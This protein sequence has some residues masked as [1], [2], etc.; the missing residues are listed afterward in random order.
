MRKWLLISTLLTFRPRNELWRLIVDSIFGID[1]PELG[2]EC[3]E[4]ADLGLAGGTYQGSMYQIQVLVETEE[5]AQALHERLSS[6]SFADACLEELGL[7]AT[8]DTRRFQLV[9]LA[10]DS[11]TTCIV[12]RGTGMAIRVL[13]LDAHLMASELSVMEERNRELARRQ[14]LVTQIQ[15]RSPLFRFSRD[16]LQW[17]LE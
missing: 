10:D 2:D 15:S 8:P 11:R 12:W 16:L 1:Y 5:Q 9:S 3:Q 13:T 4:G 17:W 6:I 7:H 14:A